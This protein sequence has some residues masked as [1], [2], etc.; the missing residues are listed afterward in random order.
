MS[1]NVGAL[2]YTLG[3]E[4]NTRRDM[5]RAR[6]ALRKLERDGAVTVPIDAKADTSEIDRAE[7]ALDGLESAFRSADLRTPAPEIPPADVSRVDAD[8]AKGE[9]SLV[10]MIG[11]WGPAAGLAAGGLGVM[12]A[13][14]LLDQFFGALERDADR[15]RLAAALGLNPSDSERA[16]RIAGRL[17]VDAWGDSL[18]E[19]NQAVEA[20]GSTLAPFDSWLGDDATIERLTA[21]ALDFANVF[22]VDVTEAVQK[23]G[24]MVDSGLARDADHA[25][26]LMVASSQKVPAALRGDVLDAIEEY[27]EHFA[28]MGL[29]GEEAMALLVNGAKGGRYELDKTGDAVKEFSIRATDMSTATQDAYAAIGMDAEDMTNRLLAGGD[30]ARTAMQDIVTGLLSI[31]N[32][33]KRAE[34]AIAL[35]GTPLED[36]SVK[37]IPDFLRSLTGL[38]DGFGSVEGRAA[39]MGQTVNDNLATDIEGIKRKLSPSSLLDAFQTGG[40][41]GVKGQL[42]DG[43]DDL[44]SVWAEYGPEVQLALSEAKDGI[45]EWWNEEGQELLDEVG[46]WWDGTG[47]PWLGEKM[48]EAL[49]AAGGMALD[50]LVD[51]VTDPGWWSSTIT[52]P[53]SSLYAEG[54][55]EKAG[56]MG[57]ATVEWL[58]DVPGKVAGM[59]AGI[60]DAIPAEFRAMLGEILDE[61]ANFELTLPE[62]RIP[63]TDKTVGGGTVGMPRGE[64]YGSGWGDLGS[65]IDFGDLL[66]SF[67]GGGIVNAPVG[68]GVLALVHGQET[69]RTPAQEAALGSGRPVQIFAPVDASGIR[70]VNTAAGMLGRR[71]SFEMAGLG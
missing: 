38:E 47:A 68:Q 19:V 4:D 7:R 64:G 70:D 15:D 67:D 46:E 12:M 30:D 58:K 42:E 25:F 49:E 28:A 23:A 2:N 27:S 10:D 41:E 51:R 17:Y 11:G 48:G 20:V 3:I 8:A 35:F 69:I 56:E 52:A 36:M 39:E 24:A 59:A 57:D 45:V 66:P 21:K 65:S 34:A 63:G 18:G 50:Y 40:W 26:D 33:A 9:S 54:M 13:G 22:G 55:A 60:W 5:D 37:D 29:T 6:Q 1:M 32:P 44:K 14:E 61:W 62:F 16:G 31:D 71:I 43:V 53:M